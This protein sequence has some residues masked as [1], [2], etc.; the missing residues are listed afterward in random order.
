[1]LQAVFMAFHAA[2]NG[3]AAPDVP[4][5]GMILLSFGVT[6]RILDFPGF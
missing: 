5:P 3:V 6:D 1:M 4:D 2:D